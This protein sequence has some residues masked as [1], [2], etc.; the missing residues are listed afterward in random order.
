M[1][2]F[3]IMLSLLV[4]SF[5][6]IWEYSWQDFNLILTI[7]HTHMPVLTMMSVDMLQ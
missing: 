1:K 4:I 3:I 5:C 7:E 2:I 6:L